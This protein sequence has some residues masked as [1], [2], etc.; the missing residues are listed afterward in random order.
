MGGSQNDFLLFGP[1]KY[2]VLY[3]AEDPKRGH[4]FD[5]LPCPSGLQAILI[6]PH[7]MAAVVGCGIPSQGS[8]IP[9]TRV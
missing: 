9:E 1:P 2:E 7:M 3:Y 4:N 6:L 5:N 8:C